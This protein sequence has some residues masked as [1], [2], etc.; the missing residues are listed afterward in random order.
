MVKVLDF[1][2]AKVESEGLLDGT[3]IDDG[4]MLGTLT[5]DGQMLDALTHDGQM[6]G[7]PDFIAPEQIRDAR[8][9]D[10]RADIYS[11]GGTLCYLLTGGPPFQDTSRYDTLQAHRSVEAAPLNLVRPEVPLELAALV[12]KMMAKEPERRFPAPAEVAEAL[13]SFLEPGANRGF[14]S[15]PNIFRVGQ[16]APSPQSVGDVSSPAQLTTLDTA[17]PSA[18]APSKP[19]PHEARRHGTIEFEETERRTTAEEPKVAPR[20]AL[21]SRPPWVWASAATGV[22]LFALVVASVLIFRTKN[23]T[24]VFENLPEQAV[25]TAD[26]DTFTVEWR[27]GKG[28]GRAQ[29]TIPPGKHVVQVTVN[30]VR[31]KG[32]EVSVES[33]GVTPFV[34]RIGPLPGPAEPPVPRIA[35]FDSAPKL[36][37]NPLG[38]T[39]V[40]VPRGE[41]E[42]GCL[43]QNENEQPAHRVRITRPFYLGA[44]EVTQGQYQTI[45]GKNPSYFSGRPR[46]PVD[47]VTWLD[48]VIFC[49]KLSQREGLPEYYRIVNGRNVT[50][51]GG[52][53]YRLP[54]EAEWEYAC[55]AGD[56]NDLPF[57]DDGQLTQLAWVGRNGDGRTH[58]VG[59][60]AANALGLYDMYGNVWEWCWD[61]AGEYPEGLSVEPKGPATGMLR[62]L[63][64]NGWWNGEPSSCRPTFRL[65]DAPGTTSPNHDFGFRVAAGGIDGL[66]VIAADR[67]ARTPAGKSGH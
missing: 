56:P 11:L 21:V 58:P 39:L 17:S 1:G 9:A 7:T 30:G 42:M 18:S 44:Y 8:H 46:N 2:L 63:R 37:E 4:Q 29:I 13:T 15:S 6:L 57:L 67:P 60:K 61:W 16:P 53:G 62:V 40:L 10:I 22:L 54:T 20:S 19:K 28:K 55:R 65:S 32:E 34:V 26:G 64:G 35:S 59:E 50:I 25:V 47:D 41:F 5:H 49:N 27:D 48:A 12:A 52:V 24:I 45:M 23:G 14:G 51:L 3:V 43:D 33:G 66:P 31:V 36:V 38:M